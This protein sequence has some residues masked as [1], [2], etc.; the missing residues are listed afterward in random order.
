[1]VHTNQIYIAL[2][3]YIHP[4]A[5]HWNPMETLDSHDNVDNKY[6]M[7]SN[8]VLHFNNSWLIGYGLDKNI[9]VIKGWSSM[10]FNLLVD[11]KEVWTTLCP[12]K[13]ATNMGKIDATLSIVFGTDVTLPM[14]IK[15]RNSRYVTIAF[16]LTNGL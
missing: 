15:M 12:N 9:K 7:N 13:V 10:A 2:G 4:L 16:G 1:M 14:M 8:F 11:Y 3:W 5:H 6:G